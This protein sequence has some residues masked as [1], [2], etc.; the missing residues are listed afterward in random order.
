M[1]G[2]TMHVVK[3][4][5]MYVSKPF[6]GEEM[7]HHPCILGDPQQRGQNQSKKNKKNKNKKFPMVSLIPPRIM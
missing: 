6:G 1:V 7:L 2:G 5:F 4:E 3:R